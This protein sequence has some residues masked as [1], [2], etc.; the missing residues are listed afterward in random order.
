MTGVSETR[1]VALVF[2]LVWDG[3][4]SRRRKDLGRFLSAKDSS[5]PGEA[6]DER[7]LWASN[8]GTV[9]QAGSCHLVEREKTRTLLVP[10]GFCPYCACT[11]LFPTHVFHPTHPS[12][13]TSSMKPS[14]PLPSS[15]GS[16]PPRRPLSNHENFSDITHHFLHRRQQIGFISTQFQVTGGGFL[17]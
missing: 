11:V 1:L 5:A 13:I 4:S 3:D 6:R 12:K 17:C 16:I 14:L 8:T 2:C 15:K 7:Q 9:D 10:P